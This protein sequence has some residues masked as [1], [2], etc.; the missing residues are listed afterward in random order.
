MENI[1][2]GEGGGRQW[3]GGAISTS[4][5]YVIGYD[6]LVTQKT[7]SLPPAVGFSR[8]KPTVAWWAS[9]YFNDL[10]LVLPKFF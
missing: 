4:P 2:Q 5:S 10:C 7:L 8:Y 9:E 3:N 1:Q 6:I